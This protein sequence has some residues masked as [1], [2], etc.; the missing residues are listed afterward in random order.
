MATEAPSMTTGS[1]TQTFT[2][3]AQ[4]RNVNR[5]RRQREG[6]TKFYKNHPAHY[7]N[8]TT[9]DQRFSSV[10]CGMTE[11][12]L[13][14]QNQ[15][16][17][18]NTAPNDVHPARTSENKH[19]AL[20]QSAVESRR[21]SRIDGMMSSPARGPLATHRNN[22]AVRAGLGLRDAQTLSIWQSWQ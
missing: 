16:D 19:A 14:Y 9:K 20:R 15:I 3:A 21:L 11:H 18:R 22:K 10:Q 12:A 17:G 7:V 2:S 13:L 4:L 8:R 1:S 6:Y 5:R